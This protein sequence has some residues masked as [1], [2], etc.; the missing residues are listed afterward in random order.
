MKTVS[1]DKVKL[2]VSILNKDGFLRQRKI[3]KLRENT[4]TISLLYSKCENYRR[5][6][7]L[8]R[9]AMII[10]ANVYSLSCFHPIAPS[11]DRN[12]S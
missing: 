8:I 11:G 5:H 3:E 7:R 1:V 9:S 4:V 6:L 10:N 2:F 12:S